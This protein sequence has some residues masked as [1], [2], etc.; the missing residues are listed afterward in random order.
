MQIIAHSART[1]S[2]PR[3]RNWRK[4]LAC[5]ICP[6]TG[7]TT[8]FLKRYRLRY[9]PYL[10]F[11]RIAWVREPP[12]LR[13]ASAG[14]LRASRGDI[15]VDASACQSFEVGLAAITRVSRGLLGLAAQ[16][17]FDAADKRNKLALIAHAWRKGV[18]HDDLRCAID[19]GLRVV[20]LDIA[21]F[22]K[23]DAAIGIGEVALGF[24][25]RL[26]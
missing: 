22:R 7:S 26:C 4:P 8:C 18:R 11:R 1:F 13:P 2:I 20:A 23:Q 3:S 24:C 6:N 9:P 14:I 19:G 16:V 15:S 25:I 5:L 12:V 10:S 17:F 21:V